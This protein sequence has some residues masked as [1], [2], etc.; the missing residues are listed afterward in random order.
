LI[1]AHLAIEEDDGAGPYMHFPRSYPPEYYD[2]LTAEKLL[3]VK[4]SGQ[5]TRRYKKIRDRNEALDCRV[6]ARA[7]LELVHADLETCDILG[8]VQAG[9]LA[10]AAATI[11]RK[12]AP[13]SAMDAIIETMKNRQRN[14]GRDGRSFVN[15]WR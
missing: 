15:S 14:A 5:P 3:V 12:G 13:A 11:Q 7:A 10:P 4:K 1:F 9:E 2:Q 6:Y 8:L